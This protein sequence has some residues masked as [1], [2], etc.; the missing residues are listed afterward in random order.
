MKGVSPEVIVF[1]VVAVIIAVVAFL[2]LSG[3]WSPGQ[4]TLSEGECRSNYENACSTY[5]STGDVWALE[6]FPES[7]VRLLKL[8]LD[9]YRTCKFKTDDERYEAC[10]N[11]CQAG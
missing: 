10:S 7:C 9:H 4:K 2:F 5:K 1:L 8:N 11:F 6:Q 3:K